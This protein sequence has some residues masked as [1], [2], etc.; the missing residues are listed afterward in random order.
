[1]LAELVHPSPRVARH[2]GGRGLVPVFERDQ[3]AE[4]IAAQLQP[5]GVDEPGLGCVDVGADRREQILLDHMPSLRPRHRT[6]TAR[7]KVRDNS[8]ARRW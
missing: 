5:I 8:A 3:L 7:G 1:L 2:R 6:C 4:R